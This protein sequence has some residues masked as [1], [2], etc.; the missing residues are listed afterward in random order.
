MYVLRTDLLSDL[1]FR[2]FF[3]LVYPSS[4]DS[5]FFFVFFLDGFLIQSYLYQGQAT[6]LPSLLQ[7]RKKRGVIN[8]RDFII[9]SLATFETL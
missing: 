7:L 8:P 5:I 1:C 6:F 2:N 9:I 3:D 4:C